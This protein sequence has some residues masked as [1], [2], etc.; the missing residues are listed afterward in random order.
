MLCLERKD[1][2]YASK[3]ATIAKTLPEKLPC[4]GTGA[5]ARS[6]SLNAQFFE[7]VNHG[8]NLR[9]GL[10]AHVKPTHHKA[11]LAISGLLGLGDHICH[12]GMG[13]AGHQNPAIPSIDTEALFL[14]STFA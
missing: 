3:N 8:F 11:Y 6:D 9:L 13:A 1:I 14:N 2:A 5:M 12:A 4:T 7:T 10:P